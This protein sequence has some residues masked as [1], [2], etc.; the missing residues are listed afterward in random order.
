MKK[1]LIIIS[2]L[3]TVVSV[4][5]QFGPQAGDLSLS[6]KMGK[7]EDFGDFMA[8]EEEDGTLTITSPF[9][10]TTSTSDNSLINM[11]GLEAKYFLSSHLAARVS[12][13]GILSDTPEQ[14]SSDGIIYSDDDDTE[15]YLYEY[16]AVA[17]SQVNKYLGCFGF[18]YYFNTRI[19][20]V[21]PY[22]GLQGNANYAQGSYGS[23][24][25]DLSDTRAEAYGLGG[26]LVTGVDYYVGQGFFLGFEIKAGYFM[27]NASKYYPEQGRGAIQADNQSI[28]ILSN[29]SLKLGFSF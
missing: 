22:I 23:T 8:V 5:A 3:V 4:K 15:V 16:S 20:R 28:S 19:E 26:S 1:Y 21:H 27:Y 7:A 12:F 25:D 2:L 9:N 6:L 11:I 18:D 29:P 17:S 13:M 14:A 24:D 10:S